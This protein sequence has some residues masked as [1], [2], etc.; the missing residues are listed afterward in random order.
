MDYLEIVCTFA[1]LLGY[2][3][4]KEMRLQ[5]WHAN[6]GW[7]PGK[8]DNLITFIISVHFPYSRLFH[9]LSDG[10]LGYIY[11][12]IQLPQIINSV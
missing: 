1:L 8:I 9:F 11:R 4:S 10:P 2:L 7:G 5:A 3:E 6:T 12:L